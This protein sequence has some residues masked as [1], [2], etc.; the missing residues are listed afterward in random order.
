LRCINGTSNEN[1][2]INSRGGAI[3]ADL[4][5]IL[6]MDDI[7]LENNSA[8]SSGGGLYSLGN[9]ILN[10]SKINNNILINSV[11]NIGAG[12][13]IIYNNGY[14]NISNCIFQN[15]RNL[16]TN[17]INSLG[18][19]IYT[20]RNKVTIMNSIITGNVCEDYG[21]GLCG[22][23]LSGSPS[24]EMNNCTIMSN[25]SNGGAAIYILRTSSNIEINNSIIS[26][27]SFGSGPILLNTSGISKFQNCTISNN[28]G[29]YAIIEAFNGQLE[30][31]SS[32]LSYNNS[33]R[34][35]LFGISRIY[36]F[37]STI[38]RNT[39]P[40]DKLFISGSDS[41]INF[42]NCTM[43]NNISTA[44]VS[45]INTTLSNTV[46]AF[47]TTNV[48]GEI[49]SNGYNF[50]SNGDG[51]SG[52]QLSDSYGTALSPLNPLLLPLGNYGG[53]TDTMYPQENSP[54][55]N[56]GS[57]G[58]LD[59]IMTT[60][61]RGYPRTYD[62]QVDI[63]SVE[64]GSVPICI[65][66]D[67][68]IETKRG[69][70][71]ISEIKKSDQVKDMNNKWIEVK[72]NILSAFVNT[73]FKFEKDCL[74]QDSPN[75]D[76][77][78]HGDHPIHYNGSEFFPNDLMGKINGISLVILDKYIQIFSLCTNERQPFKIS[79]EMLVY[80]WKQEQWEEASK[81]LGLSYTIQ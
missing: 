67:M 46:I 54:L 55:I 15:N 47:N 35:L 34:Y 40:V 44:V 59:P 79:G 76:F 20:A 65:H 4:N 12:I 66:A 63:G 7:I 5:T 28:T 57:T 49:T 48:S 58:L 26:N 10:N 19:A 43:C 39:N 61:Q 31:Y 50:I 9:L 30:I 13:C 2:G 78:I 18:G 17:I 45:G 3:Y 72:Y 32:T 56:S 29:Y 23:D 52:Y 71:K 81:R 14:I 36:I 8:R 53:P 69:I 75:A 6:S 74:G 27:N 38:Y 24:F 51:G 11:M 64:F 80:S 77:Y 21:A 70:I 1:F 73:F 60:D 37:N 25:E 42:I 68:L 33:D 41:I 22:L 62:L 16:S